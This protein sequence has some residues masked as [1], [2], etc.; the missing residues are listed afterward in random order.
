MERG[1]PKKVSHKWA[2]MVVEYIIR[3]KWIISICNN[4]RDP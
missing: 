1:I 4:L 3:F 2:N